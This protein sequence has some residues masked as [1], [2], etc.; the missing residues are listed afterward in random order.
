MNDV[1]YIMM[2][3]GNLNVPWLTIVNQHLQSTLNNHILNRF[4]L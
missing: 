2:K 4:E 3:V 1:I